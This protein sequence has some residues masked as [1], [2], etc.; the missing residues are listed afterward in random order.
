[1]RFEKLH[2]TGFGALRDLELSP[3]S[4]GLNIIEGANEAGKTT[5]LEFVRALF[6][7][8]AQRD[9]TTDDAR[10]Y[11]PKDGGAHGGWA[12][13]H[14]SHGEK[15]RIERVGDKS[16]AGVCTVQ[17]L[18]T[19]R[20]L[21]IETLLGSA[22]KTLYEQIFA[23]TLDELSGLS[24]SADQMEKR[25][26]AASS[27]N[28]QLLKAL[29]TTQ[30][31][32]NDIYTKRSRSLP[33]NI[34]LAEYKHLQ[35]QIKTLGD[36]I[37]SYNADRA[38]LQ[39]YQTQAH[40]LH[41]QHKTAERE[42]KEAK[43]HADVW[44]TWV[45]LAKLRDDLAAMPAHSNITQLQ[46][47]SMNKLRSERR[48]CQERLDEMRLR[49]EQIEADLEQ[50][51]IDK[52]VLQNATDITL[53][54]EQLAIYE[55]TKR[56]LPEL[57]HKLKNSNHGIRT[58]LE[59]L[60]EDWDEVHLA[61]ID[62]S[63]GPRLAIQEKDKHL[64][65]AQKQW[66][67]EDQTV[68][69]ITRQITEHQKSIQRLREEL[70]REFAREPLGAPAIAAQLQALEE[71]ST[72]CRNAEEAATRFDM[73][74]ENLRARQKYFSESRKN[75]YTPKVLL[76][77]WC[78]AIPLIIGIIAVL[79]IRNELGISVGI[80][81]VLIT[82]GMGWMTFTQQHSVQ[83]FKNEQQKQ[84]AQNEAEIAQLQQQIELCKEKTTQTRQQLQQIGA[85][86]GWVLNNRSDIRNISTQLQQQRDT[87]L[88]Y[89]NLLHDIKRREAD[90][91]Q[92]TESLEH[93]KN[94]TAQAKSTFGLQQE[95]WR[96][97]LQEHHLPTTATP[98]NALQLFDLIQKVRDELR[99]RSELEQQLQSLQTQQ[100][101]YETQI[102][103][104]WQKLDRAAPVTNDIPAAIRNLSA[105]LDE[106]KHQD[107]SRKT[108]RK[109]QAEWQD[110]I[111]IQE[112]RLASYEEQIAAL[113]QA[114]DAE[115]E[116]DF[117]NKSLLADQHKKIQDECHQLE[118]IL[119][120]HSAPGAARLAL[121]ESLKQLDAS[122]IE[123]RLYITKETFERCQEQRMEAERKQGEW[124]NRI[125]Q[126]EENE[127]QLS[128]LLRKQEE[129]KTH[130]AE[131]TA[132][133]A[134][135][136][137]SH[138]LLDDTRL[139]FE[140]ERQPAVI[141]RAGELMHNVTAGR[142]QAVLTSANLS[143]VELDEGEHGRKPLAHWSRG[144][145]EQF[146]L[147]LRLAFIEDYC[148]Q[149]HQE[150]LP[151]VM[152][153][154]LV[155]SDGYHRLAAASAMI[156]AFA[157]QYQVLYFTCRPGDADILNEAAPTARRFRLGQV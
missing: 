143:S 53:L 48:Q 146:Y 2:V 31:N 30:K 73:A 121:E 102:N 67:Q 106:Q 90:V 125:K 22:D 3:I 6:F 32:A 115:D 155:H 35:E 80:A 13:V 99:Q 118:R 104:V 111:S 36:Q 11:M 21:P 63:R 28:M 141:K 38:Q 84:H 107:V 54:K 114:V 83:Q 142:Y 7:G 148:Q 157:E 113:L 152:D 123:E 72:L 65:E 101:Q 149:G 110:N 26:Y 59:Q 44:P 77:V 27:G 126:W 43:R 33:L 37:E 144:T 62:I 79:L 20:N 117:D 130:I 109:E 14:N 9:K 39:E 4:P 74:Q 95:E 124:N 103:E 96:T 81:M 129:Q 133:W 41:D 75:G 131:L 112:K 92:I 94:E 8:F 60:G 132:Q 45:K 87:R 15:L 29:E 56:A 24:A 86:F 71:A 139:R 25:V 91:A 76:P 58:Q 88:R 85:P 120:T 40:S 150:P 50:Y 108:R 16:S 57:Q 47:D 19:Q 82:A 154:V 138:T 23:F 136:R 127:G 119:D 93:H 69:S 46:T 134:I 1:V 17:L 135:E 98:Q 122:S 34:A 10:R 151:V 147:A 52:V 12:I 97:W 70:Q 137:A 128:T 66:Q 68:N 51:I 89:D 55:S 49:L 140:K 116:Q 78:C 5:L 42:F 153:D 145:K 105:E 18:G 100:Q 64:N 61:K 156:A